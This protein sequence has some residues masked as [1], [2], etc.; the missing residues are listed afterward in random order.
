MFRIKYLLFSFLLFSCSVANGQIITT[1]AGNG[2][3]GYA[4]DR[5]AATAAE[6]YNPEGVVVDNAGNLYISDNTNGRV[7]K[8]NPAGIITTV[9]GNGSSI[10]SGDNG[11][12][13][14]AGI[15][16]P[17]SL[18]IDNAG[19]LYIAEDSV[20]MGT[21]E[22][23]WV[24]KVNTSGIIT[25]IAGNGIPG[26]SGD[27]GP[28][29]SAELEQAYGIAVDNAGNVYIAVIGRV[30]KV[31]TSGVITTVAGNGSL[32]YG[33]DGG[34]ATAAGIV[35]PTSLAVDNLGNLY[36]TEGSVNS[37]C[38][39]VR[40]VNTS[41]I[42]TTIAGNGIYGFSGDGGIATAAALEKPR[43]IAVDGSGNVYFADQGNIRI[44]EINATGIITTIAGNGTYGY[45]GDGAAA[46]GAEIKNSLGLV[47]DATGNIYF[48]DYDAN[49]IREISKL[50]TGVSNPFLFM[51]VP[52]LQIWPQ[53]SG[54]IFTIHAPS[55]TNEPTQIT[56]TNL[57]GQTIK[58]LSAT[59]N[60]DV[61]IKLDAPPGMYFVT[62][63]TKEGR[64]SAKI[65]VRQ[66]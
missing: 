13:T 34:P 57:I 42:I 31:S 48:S 29:T 52:V 54:G 25:T 19:N 2:T 61:E 39:Y 56:I 47:V 12:A 17:V 18:A 11:P 46:T 14:D 60:K 4:G 66:H 45:S 55:L 53:P 41:G 22:V 21:W 20:S 62:A 8:V 37:Y 59:T 10:H 51:G 24:R 28:A 7:R 33:G 3:A 1:I 9:A 6:L 64:E 49:V 32:I 63:V 15:V 26:Y 36:I 40:K 38:P 50:S 35:L 44:R 30:R 58:E 65:V 23:T 43:G 27:G 16:N 5:L